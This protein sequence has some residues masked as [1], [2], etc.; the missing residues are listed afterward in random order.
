MKKLSIT[1]EAFEKSKYFTGKYG[2]LEYVSESGKLFKTDKGK[3]LM[4]KEYTDGYE[5]LS[6]RELCASIGAP[7]HD[8]PLYGTQGYCGQEPDVDWEAD[9]KEY[10]NN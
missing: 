1:K 9:R 7:Y 8:D 10:K 6:A 4:F 5:G 2:K 3:I